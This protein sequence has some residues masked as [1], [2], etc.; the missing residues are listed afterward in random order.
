MNITKI[1]TLCE[2]RAGGIKKLAEDI[3]MT[4]ANLHRRLNAND[5][6]ASDLEQIATALGVPVT[7]FF[8]EVVVV[9]EDKRRC[10]NEGDGPFAPD[11]TATAGVA[12]VEVYKDL[13]RAKDD[14]IAE[15]R[16]ENA[17]LLALV[18][19]MQ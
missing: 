14:L 11:G 18:E 9:K 12:D 13:V 16:K 10:H 5:I 7:T 3:G 6:K 1:R 17:R 2:G 8:D 15:L 19:K 4:P